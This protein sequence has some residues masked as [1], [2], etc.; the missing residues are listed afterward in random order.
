MGIGDGGA[1]HPWVIGAGAPGAGAAGAVGVVEP[2]AGTGD[3]THRASITTLDAAMSPTL[4]W[5]GVVNVVMIPTNGRQHG[6]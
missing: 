1:D 4:R 3:P 2:V 6:R 5:S